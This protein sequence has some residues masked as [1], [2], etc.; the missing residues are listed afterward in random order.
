M[1]VACDC[2]AY[3]G[4]CHYIYLVSVL[5]HQKSSESHTQLTTCCFS[6]ALHLLQILI[7]VV[8]NKGLML[9]KLF[10]FASDKSVKQYYK[11]IFLIRVVI[12]R[13]CD[14]LQVIVIFIIS[15]SKFLISLVTC[16]AVIYEYCQLRCCAAAIKIT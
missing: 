8:S 14:I 10:V 6:S 4:M 2:I 5:A 9:Q 13:C 3:N 15:Y 11:G 16:C 1:C 7:G 12:T